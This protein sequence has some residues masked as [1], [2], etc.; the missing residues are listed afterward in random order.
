M[1]FA[2]CVTNE[3]HDANQEQ[4]CLFIKVPYSFPIVVQVRILA[5]IRGEAVKWDEMKVN[6]SFQNGGGYFNCRDG[7]RIPSK[8]GWL[9]SRRRQRMILPICPKIAWNWEN[10]GLQICPHICQWVAISSN[11]GMHNARTC[12]PTNNLRGWEDY[13]STISWTFGTKKNIFNINSCCNINI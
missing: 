12:V 4:E 3:G 10:F 5:N 13:Q 8:K 11:V 2:V 9:P 6:Y 7:S 1:H